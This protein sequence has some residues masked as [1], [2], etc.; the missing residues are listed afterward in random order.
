MF[1]NH[2]NKNKI[3]IKKKI[4]KRKSS[5]KNKKFRIIDKINKILSLTIKFE[6]VQ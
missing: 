4:I 5:K 6:K 2:L 1:R 3:N